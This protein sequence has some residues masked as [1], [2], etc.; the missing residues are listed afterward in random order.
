MFFLKQCLQIIK[1]G[2]SKG[3]EVHTNPETHYVPV[4]YVCF[5]TPRCGLGNPLYYYY[6]YSLLHITETILRA[7]AI[8]Y[9]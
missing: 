4:L 7:I 6:F 2:G 8:Q 1:V 9:I 5:M 3:A